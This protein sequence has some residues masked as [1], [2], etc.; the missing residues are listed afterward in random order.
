MQI[1]PNFIK[2][3]EIQQDLKNTL[4]SNQFDYYYDPFVSAGSDDFMFTHGLWLIDNDS[5]HISNYF[6]PIMMPILGGLKYT[7]LIRAKVNCYTKH[8]ELCKTAF[9]V[10]RDD[11]HMVGLYSVNTNNGYT[12]FE[13]GTKIE[14]VEN[15]MLIFDGSKRHCSVAQTDTKLRINININ[16]R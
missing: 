13:D 2:D 4:F 12:L 3:K 11:S 10:D 7:T 8:N 16:F 9:H 5:H 1:I 6:I 15:Q 14:S